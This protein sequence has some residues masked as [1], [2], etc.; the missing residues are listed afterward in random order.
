MLVARA[1]QQA[2]AA[3][4]P[5]LAG[6]LADRL[7][8]EAAKQSQRARVARIAAALADGDCPGDE[9]SHVSGGRAA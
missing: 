5:S 2:I 9:A 8:R 6:T 3:G 7:E 4:R 1:I